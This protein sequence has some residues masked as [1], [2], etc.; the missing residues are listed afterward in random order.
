MAGHFEVID[1]PDGGFRVRMLDP[2]GELMA[3]SVTFPSI[4][5]ARNGIELARE[6]AGTGRVIDRSSAAEQSDS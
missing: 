5:A 6:I 3:E 1:A 2:D 4:R